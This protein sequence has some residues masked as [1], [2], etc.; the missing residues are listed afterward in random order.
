M[1]PIDT[2]GFSS[3]DLTIIVHWCKKIY[4]EASKQLIKTINDNLSLVKGKMINIMY[5]NNDD[6]W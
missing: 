3:Y 4:P 6:L 1:K 2:I 5:V